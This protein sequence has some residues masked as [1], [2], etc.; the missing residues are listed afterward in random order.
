MDTR[1]I[2]TT[3][4]HSLRALDKATIAKHGNNTMKIVVTAYGGFLQARQQKSFPRRFWI[5]IPEDRNALKSSI[6]DAVMGEIR[7]TFSN[8]ASMLS[9]LTF[10]KRRLP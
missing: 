2:E 9:E 5:V 1:S 3:Q 4:P 6:G 7:C 10:R 8:L